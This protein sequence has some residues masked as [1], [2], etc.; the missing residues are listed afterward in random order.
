MAETYGLTWPGKKDAL[1]LAHT[2][3]KGHLSTPNGRLDTVER[4]LG[5]VFIEGENLEVLKL[6][7][8]EYADAVKLIYVDPPY[9]TGN[10]PVYGDDYRDSSWLSMI[11]PRL[12]RARDLLTPD[13]LIAVSIDDHELHHLVTVMNE[14]FGEKNFITILNWRKRGTG[15]QV[16]KNAIINQVEYVVC[17]ARDAAQLR[18]VGLPNE[19]HGTAR[20]RDFRKAGGQWQRRYRPKQFFPLWVLPDGSVSLTESPGAIAVH[21][22]DATGEEGFWENG[23]P[24]TAERIDA[25]E[26]RGRIIRGRWKIEQLEVAKQTTNA[27]NYLEIPSTRGTE[28]LKALLGSVVLENPKPVELIHYLLHISD[29]R[30]GDVVLDFFAGSGTTGDAVLSWRAET[31][32][33]VSYVLVTSDHPVAAGT[34]AALAGFSTVAEIGLARVRAAAD[35]VEA[36]PPRTLKLVAD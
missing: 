34:G 18:L 25:G 21:P 13:G 22:T 4:S 10:D 7:T 26:L 35:D 16:A 5:D 3:P 2:P 28:R 1:A 15:G 36:L 17:F 6:L 12:V 27:G 9:N 20:W 32:R 30:D 8:P 24:T 19:N 11:Y 23:V 29:L 33:D 14:V 31:G